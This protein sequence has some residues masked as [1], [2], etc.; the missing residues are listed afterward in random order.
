M[1]RDEIIQYWIDNYDLLEKYIFQIKYVTL[2]IVKANPEKNWN[3]ACLSENPNITWEIVQSNPN[4]NPNVNPDKCRNYAVI[5][6]R[7]LYK[8]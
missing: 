4:Y 8:K 3:Y 7:L 6:L 2:E 1:I 5:I